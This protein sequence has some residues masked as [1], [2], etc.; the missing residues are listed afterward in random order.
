M[1]NLPHDLNRYFL[2]GVSSLGKKTKM[3][4]MTQGIWAICVYRFGSFIQGVRWHWGIRK[5]LSVL[6][7]LLQKWIEIVCGINIP[8]SAK[9]GRGLY[10]GHF[11]GIFIHK[12][13]TIGENCNLS[14]GVTI[15]LGGRG[16]L[17]GVP[18][19]GDRVYIG[20]HAVIAGN[21]RVGNDVVVGA[22]AVVTKSVPDSAVVGGVPARII[23]MKGS[24][25]FVI[26]GK[27]EASQRK[28]ETESL[29][30][31]NPL[32]KR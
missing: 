30:T 11:G 7:T 26:L 23:S 2:Y 24:G 10:I 15:G 27:R 13:V 16:T 6:A 14:Q 28:D 20:P 25:D 22:N 4:L 5:P 17:M 3:V 31:C 1:K 12:D 9:I 19:I 8:F 18:S 32:E 29:I 21:I